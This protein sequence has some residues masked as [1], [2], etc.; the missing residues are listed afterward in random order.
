MKLITFTPVHLKS[1][2]GRMAA[3]VTRALV[4][5]GHVVIVIGTEGS[6]VALDECHDFCVPIFRWD[7][8]RNVLA[9]IES[10]D[11][12]VYHVGDNFAYHE[13]GVYWLE[14]FP[15]IVCLHDFYLADLYNGW[16]SSEPRDFARDIVQSWY[17][18]DTAE[19]YFACLGSDTFIEET[20]D[21]SP[22]TEWVCAMAAGVV[23]HS[24]WGCDR[25]FNS[26]PGPVRVTPLAYDILETLSR[27]NYIDSPSCINLLT[28]GHINNNK[29]VESVVRAIGSS[30]LLK[31][32]IKYRVVGPIDSKTKAFL[33]GLANEVG[34]A[35]TVSG[36]VSDIVLHEAF[37]ESNVVCALR[38]PVLE[39]A[40]A[41]AIEAMLY[42]KPLLVTDA[43]FFTELPDS[44]V[45][46][47]DPENEI[48]DVIAALEVQC[49]S[50]EAGR[51][52][53]QRA[54]SWASQTFTAEGYAQNL[55]EV[56]LQV[57]VAMPAILAT[58]YYK[59]MIVQWSG[60]AEI[61]YAEEVIG[62]LKVFDMG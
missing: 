50:P 40:S 46:K 9:A 41:S 8:S 20:K 31:K 17:G 58:N 6:K 47:I 10:A 4:S 19:K 27:D 13:G 16:M 7:D 1:A 38:W 59:N 55:I 29:R 22:M 2:I 12:S 54:Q 49:T 15:G 60:K 53:G 23:T 61:L 51:S 56:A 42:G 21:S 14:R 5:Q 36:K 30:K 32:S 52:L 24:E 44:C 57:S 34:V 43:G 26:C 45:I 3:M 33:V 11:I 28:V 39:A 48:D 62:P 18:N 37:I 25:V 35:L